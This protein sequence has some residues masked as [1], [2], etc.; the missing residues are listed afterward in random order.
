MNKKKALHLALLSLTCCLFLFFSARGESMLDAYGLDL[1]LFLTYLDYSGEEMSI[2]PAAA[3][4]DGDTVLL[5]GYLPDSTVEEVTLHVSDVNGLYTFSPDEGTDLQVADAGTDL[6]GAA[7]CEITA[8][9]EDG[10]TVQIRLYL[11]LSVSEPV[12]G[13]EE[14]A[15]LPEEQQKAPV[16]IT[17]HFVDQQGNTIAPDRTDTVW[18]GQL[19]AVYAA[20]VEGYTRVGDPA[21]TVFLPLGTSEAEDVTFVYL[22]AGEQDVFRLD[23]EDEMAQ[24]PEP[25]PLDETQEESGEAEITASWIEQE[26]E[27]EE[28]DGG[29]SSSMTVFPQDQTPAPSILP[30][31]AVKLIQVFYSYENDLYGY[32]S[33]RLEPISEGETLLFAEEPKPGYRLSGEEAQLV[34]VYPDG[35]AVPETVVFTYVRAAD[36]TAEPD[37]QM[38]IPVYYQ[39][40]DGTTVAPTTLET[41]HFGSQIIYANPA[42]L[43]DGY[44]LLTGPQEVVCSEDG[45]LTPSELVFVY[46]YSGEAERNEPDGKNDFVLEPFSGYARALRTV[47][48][49]SYPDQADS[50][51]II[52]NISADDLIVLQ[53][54]T[55]YK[56]ST[57]Y[58][59]SV[60]GRMGYVSSSVIHL[61]TE[62][63]TAVLE[64][65]DAFGADETPAPGMP[66][67]LI[68]RWG[69]TTA[70][71]RFR[72]EPEGKLIRELKKGTEVFVLSE[73]ERDDVSWYK[74]LAGG[75]TG[76]IMAQ[77]VDLF[78]ASQSAL[79]QSQVKTP[80][81]T[82]TPRLTRVPTATPTM[83]IP[84]PS[85]DPV[86]ELKTPEPSPTPVPYTGYGLSVT[87]AAVRSSLNLNDESVREMIAVDTLVSIQGQAYVEG[88]CWDSVRVLSSGVTGFMQD[89]QLRR[90]SDSE[91]DYYISNLA[92]PTPAP[93]ILSTPEPFEGMARTLGDNVPLRTDMSPNAQI[94]TLLAKDS[95]LQVINQETTPG[96]ITWCLAQFGQDIGYI[97]R[98]MIVQMN[99]WE[100]AGYIASLRTPTPEPAATPTPAAASQRVTSYGIVNR[101]RVN[102]RQEAS[103][104]SI[105]V[106]MMTRN[107]MAYILE[108]VQGSNAKTWYYVSVS[109]R[110]GYVSSEYMTVLTQN[111]LDDFLNTEDFR[112]ANNSETLIGDSSH[113]YSYEDHLQVQWQNESPSASFEPFNPYETPE[114]VIGSSVQPVPVQTA[115]M[116]PAPS[117]T[118]VAGFV[119]D[120]SAS[121]QSGTGGLSLGLIALAVGAGVILIGGTAIYVRGSQRRKRRHHALQKAQAAQRARRAENEAY[122]AEGRRE[123]YRQDIGYPPSAGTEGRRRYASEPEIRAQDGPYAPARRRQDSLDQTRRTPRTAR[124]RTDA[125]AYREDGTYRAGTENAAVDEDATAMFRR[126]VRPAEASTAEQPEQWGPASAG[127]VPADDVR[128][129]ETPDDTQAAP[130]VRRRRADRFRDGQ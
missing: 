90:V 27:E 113:L 50:G 79:K 65:N 37:I 17:V 89:S 84:T 121:G 28:P 44:D 70:R 29:G 83:Y 67:G 8:R 69:K 117:P 68:E 98:D 59:V 6:T 31:P 127:F 24:T 73:E 118:I 48:L 21:Q 71:V 32:T 1:D 47:N 18:T 94:I 64:Q 36:P 16:R 46:R 66:A 9:A 124:Y 102:L 129:E 115:T 22:P 45:T 39:A 76:W 43:R 128:K 25:D 13:E 116:A 125:P 35:T 49:R 2:Y 33:T 57:W 23:P 15:E 88:V 14:G 119:T 38:T 105:S 110:T 11:S 96:G 109:G 100:I 63:E 81:P 87:R 101:D 78:S 7:L 42:D 130:S 103:P 54:I 122:Q 123:A 120:D 62:S 99:D 30:A 3:G 112:S 95:V 111:A 19:D 51:N 114:P 104:S 97:R 72:S 55:T 91:A 12:D 82:H 108:A 77:Y 74:A 60:N 53:Q 106:Y 61:L 58:Y 80:A 93:V 126:P 85:P 10:E 75:Q 34:T 41:V 92:T 4:A 86:E 56:N 5:W 107:E 26:P 52:A 20:E 40:E